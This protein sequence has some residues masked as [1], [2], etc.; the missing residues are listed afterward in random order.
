MMQGDAYSLGFT[1]R[2]NAG[3]IVTP[4]D[5]IDVAIKIGGLRKTFL[6]GQ[7]TYVDGRWLFPFTQEET[8]RYWPTQ[9][10]SQ[11]SVKWN[12]GTIERKPIFGVRVFESIDKEVL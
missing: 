7:V 9:L 3:S 8:F 4:D 12:D 1:I 6:D 11:I 5:I 10:K 2:N